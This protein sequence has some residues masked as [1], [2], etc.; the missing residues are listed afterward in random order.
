MSDY[1]VGELRI[2]PYTTQIP[3]GWALCDGRT[4]P[5]QGN[6]ALYA[7]ISNTYGGDGKTNF[8]L[9]DLRG[10]A[11]VAASANQGTPVAFGKPAGAEAV[12]LT[13]AQ[14]TP[15]HTHTVSA[16]SS[17]VADQNA[18]SDNLIAQINAPATAKMNPQRYYAPAT[19]ALV[20]LANQTVSPS[21]SG[22]PHSNM[23][24]FLALNICIAL[25]GIYPQRS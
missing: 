2:F 23:Q 10:R 1:F 6:Q 12:T 4:L 15:Q 9:P 18:A 11:V 16:V 5:I 3:K 7:L 19:G 25:V 24:P 17:S 14:S 20:A 21:G 22:Q 8:Q 13:L